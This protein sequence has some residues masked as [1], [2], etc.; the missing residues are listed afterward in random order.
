MRFLRLVGLV[1]S[2]AAV[3]FANYIFQQRSL[4]DFFP[5]GALQRIPALYTLARWL[6]E[7]LLTLALWTSLLAALGFGLV[8]TSWPTYVSMPYRLVRIG[9]TRK[10][11]G[12][13][14]L[15]LALLCSLAAPGLLLWQASET[16][17]SQALWAAGSLAYLFGCVLISDPPL[18]FKA[19]TN[20]GTP[21]PER[22]WP[23]LLLL[24]GCFGGLWGWQ[25]WTNPLLLNPTLAALGLQAQAH[26][27]TLTI[28]LFSGES[29]VSPLATATLALLSYV[30]G[31]PLVAFQL[32]GLVS[33]LLCLVALWLLG[34]ELFRRRPRQGQF[35][36][37]LE[38]QGQWVAI[39]AVALLIIS[40]VIFYFSQYP[41]YLEPVAWGMLG[42]WALLHGLRVADRLAIGLSG[43]LIGWASLLYPSGMV[44]LP[45]AIG[46]WIGV[47][48]LQP[49]WLQSSAR[50]PKRLWPALSLFWLGG[51]L[52]MLAPQLVVWVQQPTRWLAQF[53]GK[54]LPDLSELLM[55]LSLGDYRGAPLD[56]PSAGLSVVIAPLG[57]LALGNLLLN[58]DRLVG[59]LL[60][61]WTIGGLVI[62]SLLAPHSQYW[63]TFLPLLPAL[64]LSIA[65]MLDRLRLTWLETAGTWGTQALTYLVIGL[66]AWAGLLGWLEYDDFRRTAGD[67]PSRVAQ[68][69]T[70]VN[71]DQTIILVQGEAQPVLAWEAAGLQLVAQARIPPSQRQTASSGHW[72]GALAPQSIFVLQAADRALLAPLQERYPAGQITVRRD[73]LGNPILYFYRPP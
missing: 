29:A 49:G 46:W 5:T 24:L 51:L 4:S 3:Y 6:P 8:A 34:C 59:W 57:I 14:I 21:R 62:G 53:G 52:S 65:L 72:P 45:T 10:R 23:Q 40:P 28:P 33:G 63:P 12:R 42:L 20:R 13:V 2:V 44:F 27:R 17:Y 71:R 68:Q 50:G 9:R 32:T 73:L 64:V 11:I 39:L 25:W 38:D 67:V 37:A 55:L 70:T 35:D 58:L 60:F 43:V 15:G 47:W 56:F 36:E 31:D 66:V 18:R 1:T 61:V 26:Q 16:W 30:S 48:L 19:S 7:D 22:S 41:V 69:L 54:P